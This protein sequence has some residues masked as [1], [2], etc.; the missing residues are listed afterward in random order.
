ML[1]WLG[2]TSDKIPLILSIPHS[3]ERVPPEAKWLS[4]LSSELLMTDVDRF[5][6]ELYRPAVEE[7][8]VPA[9]VTQVHRYAADLNRYPQDVD[10]DSVEG[11]RNPSGSFSKGFHWVKTTQDQRIMK[12]PISDALHQEIVKNY[13][14]RFHEEFE[15][16]IAQIRAEQGIRRIYH[17]DC[18]SMPSV[19]TGAHQDQGKKRADVVISDFNGKSASTRFKDLVL[20]IFD[21]NGFLTACNDP[22]QGGRI[23][24]RYGQPG[25]GHE[26]IQVELNRALYMDELTREKRK[27]FDLIR[28]QLSNVLEEVAEGISHFPES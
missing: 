27:E 17:L 25:Q 21:E 23:T 6:D 9:L 10:A 22:Y 26:T 3:G 13:H 16:R 24:Q 11:S 28:S 5:V 7:L 2:R 20:R 8:G 18:H 1:Q 4:G 19:G 12:A 14:D 15:K